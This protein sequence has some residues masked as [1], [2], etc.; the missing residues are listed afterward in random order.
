M[1]VQ[2][3]T[4]PE[5]VF[6]EVTT[7][8]EE[9]SFRTWRNQ[10]LVL[11]GR[12]LLVIV[13][14]VPTL[15]QI[16]VFPM[17][18]MLMFKV[19]LGDIVGKATG[20]DSAFRTVPLMVIVSAMFGSVAAATRLNVE[21][22]T[23]RLARLWVLPVNRSADFSSRILGEILRV[24][25]TTVAIFAAG[26]LIGFRFTQGVGPAI[27]MLVIATAYGACYAMFV[28]AVAV[29]V[30][31]GAPLVPFL[32][33]LSSVLMFFNS[34]FSPVDAYPGWLQPIVANQ[35]MTPAIDAMRALAVGGPVAGDVIKVAIWTALI[36]GLSFY[37]A[38][39]GY[40]KAAVER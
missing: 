35:P 14:D 7:P 39:R 31:P 26:H 10:T 16:I 11:T 40:Q 17:L 2:P 4:R 8:P 3:I 20:E 22:Q 36:G 27:G 9:K 21:R 19:V 12:Q 33:L 30:G 1:S 32:G 18:T 38:L 34:G 15:I 29:N 24:C 5:I 13:R 6:P 37:P 23:G 28:L 25:A